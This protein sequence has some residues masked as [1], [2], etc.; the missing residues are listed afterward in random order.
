MEYMSFMVYS[1]SLTD[2]ERKV[3]RSTTL[4][5]VGKPSYPSSHYEEPSPSITHPHDPP[6]KVCNGEGV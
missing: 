3:T 5:F 1:Q 2:N 4:N 6:T